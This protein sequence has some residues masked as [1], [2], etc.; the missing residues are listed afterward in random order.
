MHSSNPGTGEV[1]QHAQIGNQPEG[2]EIPPRK[3]QEPEQVYGEEEE[4]EFLKAKEGLHVETSTAGPRGLE[5]GVDL[6]HVLIAMQGADDRP[7][8]V[9]V[10]HLEEVAPGKPPASCRRRQRIPGQCGRLR[11]EE[12]R[13]RAA[14]KGH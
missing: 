7:L 12:W 9:I 8:T 1:A 14:E 6:I 3:R 2:G 10:H 4:G 11:A 5:G 13:P